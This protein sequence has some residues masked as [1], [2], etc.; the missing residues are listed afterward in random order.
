MKLSLATLPLV[1]VGLLALCHCGDTGSPSSSEEKTGE[2]KQGVCV[3]IDGT[4]TSDH[5]AIGRLSSPDGGCTAT[6]IRSR[7]IITAGHCVSGWRDH[8]AG[9]YAFSI[10]GTKDAYVSDQVYILGSDKGGV[11]DV[12]LMR[13]TKAVPR[14]VAL[15]VGVAKSWPKTGS[16]LTTYGYGCTK[17]DSGG[18]GGGTKRKFTFAFSGN[19]NQAGS[20]NL[21]PGDSGGP[22]I[23]NARGLIVGINSAYNTGSGVDLYGDVSKYYQV[24]FD[25]MAQWGV[26]Q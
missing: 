13:L 5:K 15:P 17:R 10:A 25:T 16:N 7:V 18:V 20:S 21:C 8:A 14:N 24:I 11:D 3:T 2:T 9:G 23:D 4:T 26:P 6:L 19:T 22:L 1:A 12:A